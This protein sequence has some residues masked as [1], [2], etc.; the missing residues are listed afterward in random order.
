M[1]EENEEPS[2]LDRVHAHIKAAKGSLD[3]PGNGEVNS[4]RACSGV[5]GCARQSE[6]GGH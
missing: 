6:G 4:R 3:S 5:L 1:G 2:S